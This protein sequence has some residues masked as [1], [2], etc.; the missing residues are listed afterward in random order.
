[1][2]KETSGGGE[3]AQAL[4]FMLIVL[5]AI[6]ALAV[7]YA[8]EQEYGLGVGVAVGLGVL[9]DVL[10]VAAV[11]IALGDIAKA[12]VYLALRKDEEFE[13][14]DEARKLASLTRPTTT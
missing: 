1:M 7:G 8:F 4:G 2:T 14:G 11:L 3:F 9:I 10:I 5:G 6:G 13:W 12:T